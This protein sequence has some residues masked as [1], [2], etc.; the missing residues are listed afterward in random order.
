MKKYLI[1]TALELERKAVLQLL[2]QTHPLVHPETKTRY[3]EGQW[4]GVKVT[5]GRTRA[6]NVNSAAETERAVA[7]LKPDYVF[8]L[9]VA[10]G[11]KDVKICDIVIGEDVYGY[12]RG[13]AAE[14]GF[15]PRP[16][17]GKSSY[18]LCEAIATFQYAE[19]WQLLQ[20]T[21]YNERYQGPVE[22][23]TGTIAAG[24]KVDASETSDLHQFL[25]QNCSHALAIEME[26]LGFLS[27][28]HARQGHEAL[29]VRGISDLVEKKSESDNEGN[30]HLAANIVAHFVLEFIAYLEEEEKV[31]A[32]S[33]PNS[34]S[35]FSPIIFFAKA[36]PGGVQDQGIWERAGGD[37]AQIPLSGTGK[38]Q[39]ANAIRLI[40]FG[41]GGHQIT[42]ESLFEAAKSDGHQFNR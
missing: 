11:L 17:F 42:L 5:V 23:F 4:N 14:G 20:P 6:T 34:N 35:K 10:G 27:A 3:M 8:Y 19:S 12:E 21:M 38:A 31:S 39:W 41:G 2:T 25:A 24:E 29:L 37:L 36:Y 1:L 28:M 18:E 13:K 7:F 26:G 9:G 15:R 33:V 40:K 22:V 16:Q 32:K 30:Q